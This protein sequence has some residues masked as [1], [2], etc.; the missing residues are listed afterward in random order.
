M[1]YNKK[2]CTD[3]ENPKKRF[4]CQFTETKCTYKRHGE[5]ELITKQDN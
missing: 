4:E 5:P 3:M 2:S 1:L